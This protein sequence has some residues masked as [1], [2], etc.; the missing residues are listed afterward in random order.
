[1]VPGTVATAIRID[2]ATER[3]GSRHDDGRQVGRRYRQR[4]L[5]I[6]YAAAIDRRD[7]ISRS[8]VQ[9]RWSNAAPC[10]N[11]M[12]VLDASRR[13]W[14][15]MRSD[16]EIPARSRMRESVPGK[17]EITRIDKRHVGVSARDLD[18]PRLRGEQ[19]AASDQHRDDEIFPSALPQEVRHGRTP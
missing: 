10:E 6:E 14:T 18:R 9:R 5:E 4:A 15:A 2:R 1:M 11:G 17:M 7:G 13:A 16:P 3:K 8:I 12:E 19:Q